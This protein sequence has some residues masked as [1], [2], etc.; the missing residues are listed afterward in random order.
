MAFPARPTLEER[1]AASREPLYRKKELH[2]LIGVIVA[3][4]TVAFASQQGTDGARAV[5]DNRLLHAGAGT[6]AGIV[7][8]E[9]EQLAAVRSIA[10]TPGVAADLAAL[11][12][13]DLNKLVAPLQANSTVP[14][15]DMVIP[16]GRVL[17]AVR[18]KGAP[19]PVSSHHGLPALK[20]AFDHAH[21]SRGGRLSQIVTFHRGG[22]T[23]VT[24]SPVMSGGKPV[25]A[26]LAMTPLANV[27]GRLS[28]EVWADLTV[29]DSNGNPI[30]TTGDFTPKPL[31]GADA[32]ALIAGGA[33]LTR[34]V[35]A[36]HREKL[37]R[38]IVDHTSQAVLGVSLEDDSNVVGR[39]VALYAVIGLLCTVVI[40]ATFWARFIDAR[41]KE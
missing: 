9:S 33:V 3:A 25:G 35:Y 5:L 38:L 6:D 10:F 26:V 16:D 31:P 21:G 37:G 4:L 36:D 19:L 23:L 13:P 18:S 30:V 11:N 17:L 2:L 34:N 24:I 1:P 40:I 22:A 27:L 29:Y 39:N 41:H 12:G 32:K 28:Q 14:M 15:V 8:V 20:W 7:D